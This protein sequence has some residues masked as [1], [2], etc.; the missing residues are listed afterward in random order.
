M[1]MIRRKFG[2]IVAALFLVFNLLMPVNALAD[3]QVQ[4]S[5]QTIVPGRLGGLDRYETAAIIAR[6]GWPGTADYAILAPGMDENLVDALP[7]VPLAS[8]LKAP[9]LFSERTVLNPYT[10]RELLRM[11]VKHV[12]LTGGTAAIYDSV[13]QELAALNIDTKR[14]GGRDRFETSVKI[15]KELESLG[16]EVSQVVIA[17]G[18]SHVD[19]LSVAPVAAAQGMPILLTEQKV[20]PESVQDY[21][22]GIQSKI[23]RS[24]IIGGTGVVADSVKNVCPGEVARLGGVDRYATNREVLTAFAQDFKYRTLYLA[25]GADSSLADALAGTPLAAKTSSSV[26]LVAKELS[27]TV[28]DFAKLNLSPNVTAL[29]GEGAIPQKT[30]DLLAGTVLNQAGVVKGS[31][32]P[33]NLERITDTLTISADKVTVQNANADY[34]I[35]IRGNNAILS[36][37]VV[38]GTVFVD[39][40]ETGSTVL[41]DVKAGKIVVLSGAQ[42]SIH[43]ENSEAGMLVVASDNQTRV[44]AF[45][46]TN[47]GST[48]VT[49]NAVLDA[50]GG[51]LG[52][53]QIAAQVG[54]QPVVELRGTFTDSVV[55]QGEATV[56]AAVNAVIPTLVVAPVEPGR[57]VTLEGT[58]SSVQVNKEAN[59]SLA[60][61]ARV[62]EMIAKVNANINVPP[63][64][65]VSK[66]DAGNTSTKV[67]GGGQ[68]NGTVTPVTPATPPATPAV[69]P[70]AGSGGGDGGASGTD[71]TGPVLSGVT[72]GP[73][74]VGQ[75]VSATSTESGYLYVVP[76]ATA[77][78]V[79]ALDAAAAGTNGEKAVTTAN[80]PKAVSTTGFAVGSYVLYAVDGAGNISDASAVINVVT[81]TWSVSPSYT[82]DTLAANFSLTI[83]GSVNSA[84]HYELYAKTGEKIGPRTALN[85][86]VRTVK[87]ALNNPGLLEVRF[88]AGADAVSYVAKVGLTG[89]VDAASGGL[90][91]GP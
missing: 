77:K 29:G 88:F 34:S 49:S 72:A 11:K 87:A 7:A 26:L 71:T 55:V 66:L 90:S 81:A 56:K 5:V 2:G 9:I 78:T 58:F 19:A 20:M 23:T 40:G 48:V 89:D 42:D 83:T 50:D 8:K 39:P 17:S 36:N 15:A 61:N 35:Y 53:V 79:A 57:S 85:G 30:L 33:N 47:V 31:A 6:Q 32:D 51:R 12:Y 27:T 84:T 69:Q 3:P 43:I 75:N 67:G 80:T 62:N 13:V 18:Y 68:V 76:S 91:F 25:D 22:S 38:K 44:V 65:A 4:S 37:L 41:R 70:T 46:T 86:S 14:L 24:Y 45:G 64:A 54:Q 28:T 73:V 59:I 10:K 1:R 16:A 63:S 74:A 52:E 21:L 82:G 60:A